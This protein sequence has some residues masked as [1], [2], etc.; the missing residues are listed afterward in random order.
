MTD[1]LTL[2]NARLLEAAEGY[3]NLLWRREIDANGQPALLPRTF[4]SAISRQRAAFQYAAL[5]PALESYDEGL[6]P[7]R[8]RRKTLAGLS[9]TE[10]VRELG[11]MQ[12]DLDALNAAPVEVPRPTKMLVEADLPRERKGEDANGLCTTQLA[13]EFFALADPDAA[14]EGRDTE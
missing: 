3:R 13:P 10:Q 4:P 6:A 7:V 2:T 14:P 5:K 9:E 12:R 8:E 1:T 11:E